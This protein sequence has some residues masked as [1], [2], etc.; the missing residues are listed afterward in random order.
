[1]SIC[2]K[3]NY[4]L[5]KVHYTFLNRRATTL[6]KGLN[7]YK[8]KDGR[9]EGRLYS[10]E[11]GKRTYRSFYGRSK[12]EVKVKM[13]ET[14]P[15]RE[16]CDVTV[17][18]LLVTWFDH[19]LHQVKESTASNYKMKINKHIFPYFAEYYC[20]RLTPK[21]IFSFIDMK[22]AEGLSERYISDMLVILKSAYRFASRTLRILDPFEGLNFHKSPRSEVK[23]LTSVQQRKLLEHFNKTQERPEMGIVLSL[24]TGLRIGEI[25]AMK[26]SDIDIEKRVI[27]VRRTIQRIQTFEKGRKTKLIITEPKSIK[28]RREI[29]IPDG[30]IS[31]LDN[32]RTKEDD[33][34][35]SGCTKPVEPRTMQNRF[36]AVLRK[37]GLPSV[38][39]HSLR[40][41]FATRAIEAG[42]DIKTLSE[43]LGHSSV[44]LTLNIYVHSSLERKRALM[45]KVTVNF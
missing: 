13:E 26:W 25:C 1:M 5:T 24:F 6:M 41:S 35:L 27:T 10:C 29:P 32:F 31:L 19:I 20:N 9:F 23:T 14:M 36:K 8:R 18:H 16:C 39:F 3:N 7:I 28:S 42:S 15:T 33:Y 17:G 4:D 37:E 45:D 38:H 34:I 21:Q 2:K 22:K 12:S 43:I 11:D 44:E 30:I 40:H